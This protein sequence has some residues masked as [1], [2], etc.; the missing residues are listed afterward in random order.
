MQT[1][2]LPRALPE[3]GTDTLA[4]N[5]L[6]RAAATDPFWGVREA[7]LTALGEFTDDSLE[8]VYIRATRDPRS[9]VRHTAVARLGAFKGPAIAARLDSIARN[10]SSYRVASTALRELTRADTARA[11]AAARE[12]L[13]HDSY[14]D[15]LR[16]ASL[17]A[18]DA[19]RDSRGV[20]LAIPYTDRRYDADVRRS[21][22][23]ILGERGKDST[24]ARMKM[25]V[26]ITDP[27]PDVRAAAVGAVIEWKDPEFEKALRDLESHE[28]SPEIISML[29]KALH[30]GSQ[31]SPG[32]EK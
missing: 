19:S 18:I 6:V 29:K 24:S 7:A 30:P 21:A 17:S 20:A 31:E 9:F 8:S 28:T 26:L 14:R 22:V 32:D 1:G 10:D 15:I 4:R 25:N 13:S 23:L 3:S 12:L 2:S 16:I 5:A 27:D 11:F